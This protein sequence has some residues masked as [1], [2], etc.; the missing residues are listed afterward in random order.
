MLLRKNTKGILWSLCSHKGTMLLYY[1]QT[2]FG[3]NS[4]ELN[5]IEAEQKGE[6]WLNWTLV[7]SYR[8]FF[9]DCLSLL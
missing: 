7:C 3:F 8:D 9:E 4:Q 1:M 5:S 2:E 6:K